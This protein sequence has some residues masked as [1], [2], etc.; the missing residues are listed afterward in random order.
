MTRILVIGAS[1]GIGLEVVKQALSRN[2]EVR[3]FARSADKIE[4]DAAGL[5]RWPGDA[6]SAGDLAPALDGVDAVVS[7]LGIEE[8]V[9][10]IW[11]PVSLFSKSTEALL[12]LM[13]EK[14]PKRLLIVTGIGAGESIEALSWIERQGHSFLL[15]EPYK[16]KTR[17]EEMVKA[18]S[19][20]WTIARPT[21][22]R[23]RKGTGRYKV[24]TDPKSWRMGLIPRGDVAHFLVRAIEDG[25]HIR[26]APVL[27]S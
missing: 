24:L 16:D 22:L 2:H 8:S 15:G 6:T 17:Q 21:I 3:A 4:L 18:S 1:K 5:E 26:E 11:K 9:S 14:G 7:C 27:T 23:N 13:E 19:L 10:M 20:D 12:P 25:A